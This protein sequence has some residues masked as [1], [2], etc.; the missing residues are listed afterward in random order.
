MS[1][2]DLNIG[3]K[4]F[5]F[6]SSVE[7]TRSIGSVD[8]FSFDAPFDENNLEF[9]KIFRPLSFQPV[10]IYID[11]SIQSTGT[12]I[13]INPVGGPESSRVSVNGYSLPGVL[14]DCP[15]PADEYP[16]EYFDLNLRQIAEKVCAPFG[17]GFNI[18]DDIGQPFEQVGLEPSEKVMDFLAS[19]A[20]ERGI[21]LSSDVSGNLLMQKT[22]TGS[23]PVASITDGEAG[24][25]S[26]S[27]SSDAQKVFSSVTSLGATVVGL[28]ADKYTAENSR[29]SANR[30]MVVKTDG[31]NQ[32]DVKTD[33]ESRLGRMYGDALGWTVELSS[34]KDPSGNLWKPNTKISILAPKSMIYEKY[35]FLIKTVSF[36]QTDREETATLSVVLPESFSSAIPKR[37]PW[38]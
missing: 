21:V 23:T 2:V 34:W 26:I 18:V 30:P 8:T 36:R 33:S 12:A 13:G 10:K 17:V 24:V 29:V 28:P 1:K 19:L 4:L 3:G 32:G 5:E 37:L 14:G 22:A 9:R 16:I 20:K 15:M 31:A 7:L 25:S 38:E 11:G 35:N 27:M 6:W